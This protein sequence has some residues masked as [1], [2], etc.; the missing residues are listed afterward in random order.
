MTR[1]FNSEEPSAGFVRVGCSN[2][3]WNA[4]FVRGVGD[5]FMDIVHVVLPT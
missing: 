3:R 1:K 5:P 2:V 4:I